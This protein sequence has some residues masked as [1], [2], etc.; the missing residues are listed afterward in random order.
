MDNFDAQHPRVA[1]GT[2]TSKAQSA[3][4][5]APFAG[6]VDE[7]LV[8]TKDATDP[9]KYAAAGSRGTVTFTA[10][11]EAT[12]DELRA[13][14]ADAYS[15]DALDELGLATVTPIV[16]QP[17]LTEAEVRLASAFEAR[18]TAN[19]AVSAAATDVILEK[20]REAYPTAAAIIPRFELFS[21]DD[22]FRP[23][24]INDANGD[25]L[26]SITDKGEA[27]LPGKP[28]DLEYLLAAADYD[29]NQM[30]VIRKLTAATGS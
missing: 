12:P 27:G 1:D 3:P 6:I 13:A 22:T 29:R 23:A 26:W 5:L 2:F 28:I 30:F 19:A 18:R 25:A 7:V 14:G 9:E 15:E 8:I 10:F 21:D 11:A 4:D 16:T 20:V 24:R 17:S